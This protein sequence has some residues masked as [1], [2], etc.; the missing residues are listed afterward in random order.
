MT[1]YEYK[2]PHI[3]LLLSM[4][5]TPRVLLGRRLFWT[6]KE[7]GSCMTI[8]VT[9]SYK[10]GESITIQI[11]SRNQIDASS[12]LK[13]LVLR[14]EEYPKIVK[15]LEEN[16]QFV[17]YVEACKKGR[18]VTGVK[19]YE[20]E[21]LF[22]FDMYDRSAEQFLNYNAVYQHCYHYGITCVKLYAET[23]HRTMKDLLKFKNHVYDICVAT[24]L[25]GMVVKTD[26]MRGE[27]YQAKVKQDIPEPKVRKIAKGDPIY[28]PIPE[29]E[30]M[31]AID[32][33]WQELGTEKFNDTKIAMPI[34]ARM[35]K[36]ECKKHLFSS[37]EKK[38]FGYYEQYKE[39]L[40]N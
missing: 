30:I 35:V 31:G 16:P 9:T 24:S 32:K 2:Y 23:R 26:P 25:E 11:S 20:R 28:P 27:F 29:N 7:D 1:D 12:D 8:C 19:V 21:I 18:S 10:K 4:K 6:E 38:L 3:P 15:F 33:A 40:V 34:I 36:E 14:C 37:P 17:V 13:N 22:V 39:R 5:P